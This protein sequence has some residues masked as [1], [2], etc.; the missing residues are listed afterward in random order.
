MLHRRAVIS[1]AIAAGAFLSSPAAAC[2][3]PRPKN[4]DGYT[5]AIDQAFTAWWARDFEAFQRP[6]Q[7]WLPREPFDP[8]PLF[9][10][11][12]VKSER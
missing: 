8:R 5:Q 11:H 7:H 3:A 12:F 4:R 10:A 9:D 1:A 2:K 6:L